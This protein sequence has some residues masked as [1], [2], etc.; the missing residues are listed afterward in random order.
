MLNAMEEHGIDTTACIVDPSLSTGV[1]VI[2]A[3]AE[4]RAILT[5]PGAISSLRPDQVDR[6]L[7]QQTR[8]VH[9]GSYFLL[10]QLQAGLA[11][12]FATA[13]AAGATTSLDTNW[14]PSGRWN[15]GLKQVYPHCDLF[16]PNAAEAMCI[17][18]TNDLDE[19]LDV[20]TAQ[21]PTLAVKLGATGALAR[22]GSQ[23]VRQPAYPVQVVDTVG[24]GDSFDA[25]FLYGYL[26]GWPL[27]NSL[28]LATACG[29]LSTR[30]AGGTAAQPSLEEALRV[31]GSMP[32]AER[33]DGSRSDD[34]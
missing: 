2:L 31:A 25:G 18:G 32:A 10:W 23:V 33:Y 7:L 9:C 14:D 20:L 4:D 26:Q 12:I 3:H 21:V 24:A 30:A 22:H 17:S 34:A 28:R 13:R 16:L 5:Y 27:A 11:D 19:A 1:S 29:S 8:H 15:G 6:T